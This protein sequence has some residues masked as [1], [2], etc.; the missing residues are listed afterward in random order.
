MRGGDHCP[1]R[2]EGDM[3]IVARR[4]DERHTMLTSGGK[5]QN[6]KMR[7]GTKEEREKTG[8]I[9]R[10]KRRKKIEKIEKVYWYPVVFCFNEFVEY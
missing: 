5:I 6:L 2:E 8:N 7:K 1:V 9:S 4:A 10:H 3:K